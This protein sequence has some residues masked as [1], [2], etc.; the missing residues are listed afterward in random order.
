[1]KTGAV[2][3]IDSPC[4]EFGYN[5]LFCALVVLVFTAPLDI[6]LLPTIQSSLRLCAFAPLRSWFLPRRVI[7]FQRTIALGH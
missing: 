5:R 1:M 3:D 2:G 7:R 4:F 6:A